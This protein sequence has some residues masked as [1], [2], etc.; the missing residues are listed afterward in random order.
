MKKTWTIFSTILLISLQTTAQEDFSPST[1]LGLHTGINL[2]WTHFDPDI[3]QKLYTANNTGI[4]FRH[5]S[6]P[7]IGLQF[8]LN[9]SHKGWIEDR[10]TLGEYK[11]RLQ[12]YDMPL[13]AVFLFGKKKLKLSF[14]IGPYLTYRK[15][16][17]EAVNVNDTIYYRDYYNVPLEHKWEF[18][19][20][21]GLGIELHYRI[22]IFALRGSYSY[23]ITSLFPINAPVFYYDYSNL[24]VVHISLAYMLNL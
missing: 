17:N 19:L 8:E 7:K 12:V 3:N 15:K 21:A 9:F 18:G 16:E 1:H 11:R 10:D 22:G 23:S 2:C 13:M 14:S 24:Q 5:I 4:I 6:E 20:L